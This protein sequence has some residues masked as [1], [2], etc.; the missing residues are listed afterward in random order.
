MNAE[1]RR[2]TT[3]DCTGDA[4]AYVLGA[5]EPHEVV[6][7]RTH[8]E[9]CAICRD[10]IAALQ[11]VVDVLPLAAPQVTAPRSLRR[12]VM[13]TVLAETARE[14][15]RSEARGY[16]HA[17]PLRSLLTRPGLALGAIVAVIALAFAAGELASGGTST[18]II[19]ASVLGSPGS[20]ELRLSGGH[21]ELV[22]SRLPSP[23]PGHI[24]EVWLQR[25]TGRPS[26]T[27]ALFGVTSKGDGDVGVPGDL[28]GVKLVMVTPEPAGGSTMPTHSPVIVARL[29]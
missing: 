12:R 10:E 1:D 2:S 13:R 26:P 21:A 8:L 27:R 6:A 24:Y 29:S 18:R 23:A 19:R 15:E 22:V 28:H 4:A 9:S 5:L 16:G 17:R 7:F 3:H 14:S 11:D 20:A 25:A